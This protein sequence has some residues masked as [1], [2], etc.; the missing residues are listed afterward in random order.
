MLK[1]HIRLVFLVLFLQL[2]HITKA[3]M[4]VLQEVAPPYNIKTASFMKNGENVYPFFRLGDNFQFVFDDLFGNEANYYYTLT[5]CNYDWT[6]SQLT[7]NEYLTGFDSQRIQ[8]YQNS[9]NTLQIYSHYTLTFPNKF[10]SIRL[11][12][13]YILNIL[14]EDREVILSRR[15]IVYE[16]KVAVPLQV[17]R[18]RGMNERDEAHNMDFSI[19]TNSFIFQMPLQNVKVGIFQNGRFD[20]AI[21]NIKPQYTIGNDLIY[22]YDKETQFWAGNEYLY[23]DNKDIRNAVNN[24]ARVTSGEIYNNILYTNEARANK[25][26]T[27]YPDINGNFVPNNIN[28]SVTDV[29]LESDYAWIFFK[30]E[31]PTFFEKEDIYIGGMFNNYAKTNE[32]KMEYNEKTGTYEKAVMIKQGF[33]NYMY[34]A[35]NAKGKVDGKNAPDGNFFQ[36][37]N[38]YNILVYYRENNER[39]DR[40]IGYGYANSEDIIN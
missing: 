16:E 12:G 17:K 7:V 18:A 33:T 13:N 8:T 4:Q 14:N 23:F 22:R 32:Y 19:K 31:A 24:I 5:H 11:T 40:V 3:Q 28:L 36:T 35:A 10:T 38:D 29:T 30:F 2:P 9:F 34:I 25:P 26:Y 15:F 27:Y 39:Y 1:A 37:E 6:K 21:Y 20:N